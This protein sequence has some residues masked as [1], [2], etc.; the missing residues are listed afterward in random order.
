[1]I[2]LLDQT[3]TNKSKVQVSEFVEETV[4]SITSVAF[5]HPHRGRT[6]R[7]RINKGLE[8]IQLQLSAASTL[9]QPYDTIPR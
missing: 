4:R 6:A 7:A 9:S 2:S 5:V 1:M 3:T 8:A